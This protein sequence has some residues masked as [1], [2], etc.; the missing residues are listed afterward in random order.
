[1]DFINSIGSFQVFGHSLRDISEVLA[2]IYVITSISGCK[3]SIRFLIQRDVHFAKWADEVD[4]HRRSID[5]QLWE[6]KDQMTDMRNDIM[7]LQMQ[8]NDA[9]PRPIRQMEY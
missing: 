4:P 3:N 9:K 6:L 1:M 5:F 2:Y 7:D 8:L